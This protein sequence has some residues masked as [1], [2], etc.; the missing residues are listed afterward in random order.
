MPSSRTNA[1]STKPIANPNYMSTEHAAQY[2]GLST[3]HFLRKYYAKEIPAFR[4]GRHRL[5]FLR[6][7]VDEWISKHQPQNKPQNNPAA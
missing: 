6:K 7:D 2:C 5:F 1:D 3:R 4:L